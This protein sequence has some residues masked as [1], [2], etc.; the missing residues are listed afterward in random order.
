MGHIAYDTARKLV[1][2]EL[3]TG[4]KLIDTLKPEICKACVKAKAQRKPIPKKR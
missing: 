1:E 2:K 3:V 4:V